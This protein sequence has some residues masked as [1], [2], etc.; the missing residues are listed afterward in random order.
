MLGSVAGQSEAAGRVELQEET[1]DTILELNP[2]HEGPAP[3]CSAAGMG[4]GGGEGAVDVPQ[5]AAAWETGLVTDEGALE[6]GLGDG[7]PGALQARALALWEAA[8]CRVGSPEGEPGDD[9][10]HPGGLAT[11]RD[12]S[13][14][15]GGG[16]GGRLG[17]DGGCCCRC[18]DGGCCVRGG[19]GGSDGLSGHAGVSLE[20]CDGCEQA[21]GISLACNGGVVYDWEG[22]PRGEWERK[23]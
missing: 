10:S 6:R 4:G 12:G 23:G 14:G 13:A 16:D 8:G 5:D 1:Q 3:H 7:N 20:G 17:G 9:S 22:A 21:C 15:G 18:N 11:G 2:A 19:G